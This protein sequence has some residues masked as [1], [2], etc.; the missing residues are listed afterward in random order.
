MLILRPIL[1]YP[2]VLVIIL[3]IVRNYK[4]RTTLIIIGSHRII[5]VILNVF[6][7]I[8][9]TAVDIVMLPLLLRITTLFS[10]HANF[11]NLRIISDLTMVDSQIINIIS[12]HMPSPP[13]TT[14]RN[15]FFRSNRSH[16][17]SCHILHHHLNHNSSNNHPIHHNCLSTVSCAI[18]L[19]IPLATVLSRSG[20][21]V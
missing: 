17:L 13:R 10:I 16:H 5:S 3:Q 18:S 8:T 12:L 15:R 7:L 21:S 20:D 11:N 14:H 1:Y 9:I 19:D 4:I 6:F 2:Q